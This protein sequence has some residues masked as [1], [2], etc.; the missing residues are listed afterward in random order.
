MCAGAFAQPYKEKSL[1]GNNTQHQRNR[2]H[3]PIKKTIESAQNNS[4]QT[5]QEPSQ[6]NE[7]L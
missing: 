4:K 2:K 5:H 1:Q 7:Q 3:S 6:Q